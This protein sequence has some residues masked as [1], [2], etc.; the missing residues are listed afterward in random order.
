[1]DVKAKLIES[2][3]KNINLKGIAQDVVKGIAH[4]AL[5]ETVKKSPTQIDDVV[6]AAVAPEL[7]KQLLVA[8]EKKID[9][10]LG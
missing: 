9:E 5:M 8:V 4:E 10:L 1:M 2:I 6:A 3:K 7:E